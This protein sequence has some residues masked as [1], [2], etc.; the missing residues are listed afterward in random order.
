MTTTTNKINGRVDGNIETFTKGT[1]NG[2][3]IL[4]RDKDGYVNASKLGN[5]T[6]RARKF[7]NSDK[8]NEMCK[9]WMKI[10]CADPEM[11]PKYRLLNVSNEFKGTYIHPKLVHFV[12]EWVDLEY[13]FTVSEIMDQ[14]NDKVHEELNKQQLPDTVEN[15]KPIFNEIAKSIAPNIQINNSSTWG[16]RDSPYESDEF[17]D[18][19]ERLLKVEQKTDGWTVFN[20][21]N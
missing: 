15:S 16:Y 17:K 10:R 13:A 2:I 7:V 4:I 12:A 11:T 5:D 3:A 21:P 20:I 18:I 14:I 9:K 19:K 1:Y 8:F 6:R